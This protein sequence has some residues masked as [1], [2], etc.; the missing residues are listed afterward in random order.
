ME[1]E[2]PP[3]KN[4]TTRYLF[5]EEATP[6]LEFL[7]FSIL[8]YKFKTIG[9][10]KTGKFI[11]F[12]EYQKY[13]ANTRKLISRKKVYYENFRILEKIYGKIKSKLKKNLR[14]NNYYLI[15][16][17]RKVKLILFSKLKTCQ[18]IVPKFE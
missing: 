5:L 12:I 4:Q 3:R 13:I 11:D 16:F 18:C 1:K 7:N 14:L 10:L 17:I 15:I 6:S 9:L 8:T 2:Y